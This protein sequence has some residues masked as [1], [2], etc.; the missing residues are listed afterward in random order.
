MQ[1]RD[2][3]EEPWRIVALG[4]AFVLVVFLPARNHAWPMLGLGSIVIFAGWYLEW[5][6]RV[7]ARKTKGQ[8]NPPL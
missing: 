8:S 7:E 1:D 2:M 4:L 3:L 6:R 5:R